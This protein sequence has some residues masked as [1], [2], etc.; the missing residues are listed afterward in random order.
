M[1]ESRMNFTVILVFVLLFFALLAI[2]SLVSSQQTKRLRSL[3]LLP[4]PGQIA[5]V[6]DV[7][8]LIAAGQKIQAIKMYRE[9]Y[10]VGLKEAKDAVEQM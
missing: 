2:V 6:E 4:E 10:G 7:K 8:R 3:G 1:V 9:I 5:T